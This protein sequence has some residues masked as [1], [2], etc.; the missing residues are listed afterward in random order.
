MFGEPTNGRGCKTTE[1]ELNEWPAT[2]RSPRTDV[3]TERTEGHS[4]DIEAKASSN[5]FEVAHQHDQV[6]RPD[7]AINEEQRL[8]FEQ[9]PGRQV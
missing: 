9:H 6:K 4:E 3:Y 5:E 2:P 8:S 7:L 1:Y